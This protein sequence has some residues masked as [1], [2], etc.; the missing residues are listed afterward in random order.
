M[1]HFLHAPQPLSHSLPE[2][3]AAQYP[4]HH[5]HRRHLTHAQTHART[6]THE[7]VHTHL[8]GSGVFMD[9]RH[10]LKTQFTHTA[11][12]ARAHTHTPVRVW[13]GKG[14]HLTLSTVHM[15][16]PPPPP[17]PLTHTHKRTCRAQ[18]WPHTVSHTHTQSHT[19]KRTCR[20][21][22]W[23]HTHTH[24][25]THTQAHLSGSGVARA[26]T[27]HC[28]C[29]SASMEPK[30]WNS[31][32]PAYCEQIGGSTPGIKRS[33]CRGFGGRHGPWVL[34]Q[35]HSRILYR[36]GRGECSGFEGQHGPG[37]AARPVYILYTGIYIR[38]I[39]I[40]D[41]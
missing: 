37:R 14:H 21:Q 22:A 31:R 12:R 15:H 38:Y 7:H 4:H 27:S 11:T 28:R 1:L 23:P 17:V 18:A 9:R 13:R 40:Y 16:E 24:T 6:H 32:T 35:L 5:H 41:T 30:S 8:S 3:S 20:G 2:C 26:T 10:H 39:Y 29:T 36:E 34:G 25:H 33:E 19:H